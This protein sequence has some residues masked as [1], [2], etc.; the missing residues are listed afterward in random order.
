MNLIDK[1][2][3][4]VGKHLPRKNRAD[5]EAEIRSTL[6]DMLEERNQKQGPVEEATVV[7]LLKEYGPPRQVAESYTGPRY[8]IGPRLFPLFELVTKIVLSVLFA[9]LLVFVAIG[10]TR[11]DSTGLALLKTVGESSLDLLGVLIAVFGNIVLVFAILERVLPAKD[12]EEKEEWTPVDL[13]KEPDPDQVKFGEQIFEIFFLVLFLIVFNQY[14]EVIG[15]GFFDENDWMF[16]S[17]ILT[18]AFFN[19]LPWLNILFALQIGFNIYLL[20]QGW[21]NTGLR[22]AN[23]LLELG[24]LALAIA[25]L[26]GPA[27]VR[28]TEEQ[29]VGTPLEASAQALVTI[30][31]LIPSIVLSIV[32]IISSIE[33]AQTVYRLIKTG[34]SSPYPVLK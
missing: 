31:N 27:L 9:V 16:I 4:E 8:L 33:I 26:R 19:Y 24:S 17:P 21:W 6:E 18:E 23:G 20:R 28:L 13:A 30:G 7:E 10:L 22:I 11:S 15:I 5:I 34:T 29:L 3:V 32:I 25:M 14:P 2:I 1:Y 12:L